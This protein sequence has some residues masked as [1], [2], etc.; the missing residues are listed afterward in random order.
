MRIWQATVIG[1][2]MAAAST[3]ASAQI[4]CENCVSSSRHKPSSVVPSPDERSFNINGDIFSRNYLGLELNGNQS[5]EIELGFAVLI[6]TQ[7]FQSLFVNENGLVSFGAAIS[8]G[9]TRAPLVDSPF[10]PVRSLTDFG[11]PVIAPVYADL[12]EG[13]RFGSEGP[14]QGQIV[15]QYGMA[16]PT[17][18]E[19]GE[20]ELEDALRA[21][22]ITWYGL[23]VVQEAASLVDEPALAWAQLLITDQGG[24]DFNFEFRTGDPNQD[25]PYVQPGLGSIAGFALD[26]DALDFTGPYGDGSP[27]YF[28]FR[29]GELVTQAMVPEATT[30]AM[31]ILGLG[32]MGAG[33]R[34]RRRRTL[35]PAIA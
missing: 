27:S 25:P 17:P 7:S 16:D 1:L 2:G 19:K 4:F 15:V 6:G 23:P 35:V 31:M 8:A 30:W 20:Y 33:L 3:P 5:T 10:I 28:A 11:I 14:Y 29:D 26:D 13:I 12:Q 21:T 9:V 34:A 32:V 22:R 18:N 24:G